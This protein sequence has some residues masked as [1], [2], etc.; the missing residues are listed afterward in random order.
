MGPSFWRRKEGWKVP[1]PDRIPAF[2]IK[3]FRRLAQ[4]LQTKLTEILELASEGHNHANPP[5]TAMK[6]SRTDHLPEYESERWV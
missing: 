5:K 3:A 4:V 2:W 6:E 1:G